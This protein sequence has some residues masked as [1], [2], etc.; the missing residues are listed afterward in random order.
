MIDDFY[1]YPREL[2]K[3]FL[4]NMHNP[5]LG[6]CIDILEGMCGEIYIHEKSVKY[7]VCGKIPKKIGNIS[8]KEINKRFY[9]EQKLQLGFNH[10]FVNNAYDFGSLT[11]FHN[12]KNK[13]QH[14]I[15]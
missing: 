10:A 11:A 9:N 1:K 7:Y 5:N 6:K 14:K 8:E 2:K 12:E 13:K 15:K 4:E 3:I